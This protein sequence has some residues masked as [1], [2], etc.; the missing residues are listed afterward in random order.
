MDV[1]GCQGTSASGCC[2]LVGS[3]NVSDLSKVASGEDEANISTDVREETFKLW[4][5][6]D[7]RAQSTPN[8]R[9]F[10]HQ[11]NTLA[12]KSDTNLVHLVGTNI[13]DIDSEDGG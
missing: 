3:D 8:H 5:V 10:A 2:D 9:I 4:V 12:A 13:V 1:S 6:C 11:D 7:D